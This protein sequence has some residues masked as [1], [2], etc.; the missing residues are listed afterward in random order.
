MELDYALLIPTTELD[1]ATL[2]RREP[3][4]RDSGLSIV[5]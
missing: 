4:V 5:L 2:R 1:R 3:E